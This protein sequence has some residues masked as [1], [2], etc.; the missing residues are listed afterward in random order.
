M[1]LINQLTQNE[2][3]RQELWVYFLSGT[4]LFFLSKTLKDVQNKDYIEINFKEQIQGLIDNPPPQNFIDN[5]TDD[6]CIVVCLLILG[7]DLGIIS[8]YYGISE[9]RLNGILVGLKDNKFWDKQWH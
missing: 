2:D 4:P 3:E 5:L 6:E 7:C 8:K 1:W 9:V